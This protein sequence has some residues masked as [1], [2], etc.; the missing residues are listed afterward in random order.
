MYLDI[1]GCT[2]ISSTFDYVI[3]EFETTLKLYKLLT[4]IYLNPNDI[5]IK[6]TSYLFLSLS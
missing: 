3:L 5:K 2:K 6:V 1:F 4:V